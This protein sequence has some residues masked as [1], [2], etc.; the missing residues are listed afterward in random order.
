VLRPPACAATACYGHEGAAPACRAGRC[1]GAVRG[2]APKSY[3]V[4]EEHPLP[5]WEAWKP[6][7]LVAER[8]GV[9]GEGSIGYQYSMKKRYKN[10]FFVMFPYMAVFF[11]INLTV[12]IDTPINYALE[13]SNNRM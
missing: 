8:G 4:A 5:A 12:T 3:T 1:V 13:V 7:L 6:S 11:E 9:E 10:S 2:F